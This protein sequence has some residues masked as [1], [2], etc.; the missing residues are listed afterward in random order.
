MG[1][2]YMIKCNETGEC[3]VGSTNTH[4]DYIKRKTAHINITTCSSK[5]IIKRGNY[6]FSILEENEFID[7]EL[8]K[9]E[10][11]WI[12]TSDHVI[13]ERKAYE[14]SEQRKEYLKI[15][16][17]KRHKEIYEGE[18]KET[19]LLKCRE[20]RDKNKEQISKKQNEKFDC[21]CGGKYSR[22]NKVRHTKSIK[23]QNYLN[24]L[25]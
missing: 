9:R 10:Q 15:Y 1:I 20:Y 24:G 17:E 23:H 8:R 7:I 4:K 21:E 18:Y 11:Y 6:T 12:H 25:K 3:Y 2:V 5:Q 22:V 13:N 19:I 16:G 14:S